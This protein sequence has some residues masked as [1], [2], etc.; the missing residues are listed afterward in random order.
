MTR[1]A[2]AAVALG[3]GLLAGCGGGDGR[4]SGEVTVDGQPLKKGQVTFAPADG[5]SSGVSAPVADGRYAAVVPAGEMTVRVSGER[6]VGKHQMYPGAPEV[7]KVEEL[8]AAE[9][10]DQTTLTVTIRGGSQ[11]ENFAVKSRR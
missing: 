7:D 11:V 9:Y 2:C 8:V 1:V 4:V 3:L 5:K 10:N 6:V